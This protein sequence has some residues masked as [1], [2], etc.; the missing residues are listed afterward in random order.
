ML[1]CQVYLPCTQPAAACA[2]LPRLL[3]P[4]HQHACLAQHR[5]VAGV[6][7]P[8]IILGGTQLVACPCVKPQLPHLTACLALQECRGHPMD[9]ALPCTVTEVTYRI[10]QGRTVP[11]VELEEHK[12]G[13]MLK[14]DLPAPSEGHSEFVVPYARWP[15]LS[16]R[17]VWHEGDHCQVGSARLMACHLQCLIQ[18]TFMVSTQLTWSIAGRVCL[19]EWSATFAQPLKQYGTQLHC[20]IAGPAGPSMERCGSSRNKRG[21]HA[22]PLNI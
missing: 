12:T 2:Q 5:V 10:Q 20:G 19:F 21:R 11:K 16:S 15:L 17:P 14:F 3:L 6:M 8:P 13:I 9:F 4:P 7:P 18:T 1:P 22:S